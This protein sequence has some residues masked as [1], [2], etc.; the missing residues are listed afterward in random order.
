[1]EL[2]KNDKEV[3]AKFKDEKGNIYKIGLGSDSLTKTD[4]QL[5]I[6]AQQKYDEIKYLEANPPIPP[7]PSY[8]ELR[9]KE[10]PSIDDMVVAL[11]EWQ[12][13]GR[14]ESKDL[15]QAK[16]EAVKLKYPKT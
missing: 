7:P 6:L 4:D 9:K 11:W 8:Q 3:I 13:E 12:V 10:Y 16:R 5:K 1:M 14:K 2:I 15:L